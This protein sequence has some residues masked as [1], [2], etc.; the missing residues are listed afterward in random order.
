[1]SNV[2]PHHS[3]ALGGYDPVSYFSGDPVQGDAALSS[4]HEGATYYFS[5]EENKAAFDADPAKYAPQYGGFCA[6]AMSEGTLF[7]ADPTNCKITDDRLFLFYRGVGGDTLP[8]WN[9]NEGERLP[10]ADTHWQD[11]SFAPPA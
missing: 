10:A 7:G 6:T 1:M 11:E 9:E 3:I 2:H 4:E 5:L 8:Q